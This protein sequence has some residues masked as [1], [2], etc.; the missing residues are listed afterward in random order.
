MIHLWVERGTFYLYNISKK[1]KYEE[2]DKDMRGKIRGIYYKRILNLLL[3][4]LCGVVIP[5]TLLLYERAR[6]NVMSNINQSNER[7]LDQI[8]ENYQYFSENM[9]SLSMSTFF[10][11]DVQKLIY[12]EKQDY[13][14]IYSTIKDLN[15]NVT[16]LQ[17]SLQSIVM[18]NGINKTY[19]ST[20]GSEGMAIE[21]LQSFLKHNANIPKLQPVLR[22]VTLQTEPTEIQS[23]VF[24]YFMYEYDDPTTGD[25][26]F[27]VLNQT[28]NMFLDSLSNNISR[29]SDITT[30]IYFATK[31]GAVYGNQSSIN[32]VHKKLIKECV[33]DKVGENEDGFYSRKYKDEEYL[34]SY[35]CLE[36]KDS[37]LVMVQSY[38]DIFRNLIQLQKEFFWLG[39]M[40]ILVALGVVFVISVYIYNPVNE[41]VKYF[42]KTVG[43][44]VDGG[45]QT[46]DEIGQIRYLLQKKDEQ[47]ND[48]RMKNKESQT[49][50]KNYWIGNL[51]RESSNENWNICFEKIPEI[52]ALRENKTP[53]SVLC[54]Q[55]EQYKENKYHFSDGDRELLLGVVRNVIQEIMESDF[56]SISH[57]NGSGE[58]V[59]IVGAKKNINMPER[60]K[61]CTRDMQ[62]FVSEHFDV[63]VSASYSKCSMEQQ[64]LGQLYQEAERYKKYKVIY[65]EG[66]IIGEEE[67]KKNIENKMTSYSVK[68]KRS[69]D[70]KIK[71]GNKEQ[72]FRTLDFIQ[73]EISRLSYEY[74]KIN[75]MSLITR[76]SSI[77]YEVNKA[78]N[79]SFEIDFGDLYYMCLN[80]NSLE[81]V[82]ISLKNR[83]ESILSESYQVKEKEQDR[84]NL[85]VET[86]ME[87]VEKNYTNC[88]F[89]S[90]FI[91]EYMN[92]SSQYIMKKFKMHTGISLNEYILGVRMKE[93][94][95]LL[96]KTDM[97]ISQ[98]AN[99]LGIENENYFY[100]LFKKVY[101]YTPREFTKQQRLLS[102]ENE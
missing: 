16:Q 17:P 59:L 11:Y 85:F 91:A 94:A 48:Q 18:Y 72:I 12:S 80:L 86:V 57:N 19:Y 88:N 67:C 36:A 29:K 28:A 1:G 70:E 7:I 79:N 20:E 43:N 45:K 69:L 61:K 49:I 46:V 4:F 23:W 14:E 41:L 33:E 13:N 81:E 5:F 8:S 101:G 39:I 76:V 52:T 83:I 93:A 75:L 30:S 74:M 54:L 63:T 96:T 90:Q 64:E 38:E 24:S 2:V 44:A 9:A 66:G 55:L 53:I 58:L 89:S 68:L 97:P 3:L 34:I 26:S 6:V 42:C 65:G 62:K 31:E 35:I 100:R 21:D 71:L 10:R 47:S 22:K 27:I 25:G 98:V 56:I 92:L 15:S 60:L 40:G 95:H 37:Y 73:E 82:F 32:D 51:L 99:S 50:M 78:K 84:D 77:V 102:N 87:I